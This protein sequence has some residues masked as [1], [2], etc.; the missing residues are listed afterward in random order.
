MAAPRTRGTAP[1]YREI[2]AVLRERISDGT[3]PVG[4]N[5]PSEA[6]LTRE[7]SA[8]RFTVR[9]ALRRLQADG[10]LERNQGAGSKVVRTFAGGV[11]VQTYEFMDQIVQFAHA[12]D[13]RFLSS[14]DV[15]LTA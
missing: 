13:F 6:E 14:E 12:T 9:E 10:I 5:L 4:T 11:F 8:S 7:F 15:T 2:L 1:R 3:Y